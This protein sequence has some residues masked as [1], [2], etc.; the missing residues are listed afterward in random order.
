MSDTR[1][2]QLLAEHEY[3]TSDYVVIHSCNCDPGTVWHDY[4]SYAQHLA[5]VILAEF[6]V[7]PLPECGAVATDG[8]H[9]W[10]ADADT[11]PGVVACAACP[12][13]TRWPLPEDGGP[14]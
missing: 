1:L 12:A 5:G 7:V 10:Q 9:A 6:L 13:T 4:A 14:Q 2:V 11:P 8:A 3:A